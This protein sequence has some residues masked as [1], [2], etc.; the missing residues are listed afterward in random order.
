MPGRRKDLRPKVG[1]DAPSCDTY[2]PSKSYVTPNEKN[3]KL[4]K[5]ERDK[6]IPV[7]KMTPGVGKY[8]IDSTTKHIKE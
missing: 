4:T 6:T 2:S 5:D 3:W 7:Y 8:H 1:L